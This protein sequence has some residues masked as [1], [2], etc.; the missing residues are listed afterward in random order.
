M[1][2]CNNDDTI[3]DLIN[4]TT[5][6]LTDEIIYD[7]EFEEKDEPDIKVFMTDEERQ[8]FKNECNKSLKE[9]IKTN[10][11]LETKEKRNE[12]R[13][14]KVECECGGNYV[15]TNKSFHIKTKRHI[16]YLS[17]N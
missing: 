12:A 15:K 6:N 4:K 13:S 11:K 2:Y 16:V 9:N 5:H 14:E 7:Y 1:L 17:K 3:T 8:E 10:K